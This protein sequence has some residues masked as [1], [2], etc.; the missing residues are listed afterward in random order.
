MTLLSRV[1]EQG[2]TIVMITDKESVAELAD[3]RLTLPDGQLVAA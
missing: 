1:H 2:R 3:R